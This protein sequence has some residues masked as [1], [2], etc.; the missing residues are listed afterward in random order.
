MKLI[1]IS[2]CDSRDKIAAVRM[3]GTIAS[4][5]GRLH[6]VWIE[7]PAQF[8]SFLSDSG[9]CWLILMMAL[10]VIYNEDVEIDDAVDPLLLLGLKAIAETW[11]KWHK[12]L[13]VPKIDTRTILEHFPASAGHQASFFTGGIDSLHTVLRHLT[14][15]DRSTGAFFT[16]DLVIKNYHQLPLSEICHDELNLFTA[17][18]GAENKAFVPVSSNVM[19]FDHRFHYWLVQFTLGPILAFL[20]HALG[21]GISK[22]LIASPGVSY[23]HLMPVSTHPLTD[24]LFSSTALQVIHDGALHARFEKTEYI[25]TK[26]PRYLNVLS[27]CENVKYSNTG[28]HNC[29]RCQKCIRTM[30]ALDILDNRAP[31][32]DWANYDGNSFGKLF[33]KNTGEVAFAQDLANAARARGKDGIAEVVE[34][35][36]RRSQR[37]FWIESGLEMVRR[38]DF[39]I[40]HEATLKEIR[41]KIFSAARLRNRF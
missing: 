17:F 21:K 5:S 32:F 28:A 13:R 15:P 36:V 26:Y 19:E 6:E 2:I 29:S 9:D 16:T 3:T 4:K 22:I 14:P 12:K 35:A 33:F 20:A 40:E 7:L 23:E 18:C 8:S 30:T 39:V 10:G 41:E 27:V 38:H 1:D 37:L 11:K 31:S 25:A 34:K 24:P